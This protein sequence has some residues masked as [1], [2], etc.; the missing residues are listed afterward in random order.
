MSVEEGNKV[1]EHEKYQ[2]HDI[3]WYML[4]MFCLTFERIIFKRKSFRK[5][6]FKK[7][8]FRE[9]FVFNLSIL[10]VNLKELFLFW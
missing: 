3:L 10:K 8:T 5:I 6:I 2:N 1:G 4:W 7:I 9:V